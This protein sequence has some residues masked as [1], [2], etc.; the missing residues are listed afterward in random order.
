MGEFLPPDISFRNSNGDSVLLGDVID[1]PLLLAFVY[2][3]CPGICNTTLT[4]LAW[5]VDRVDLIPKDDFEVLCIS[6]DHEETPE[7]ALNSKKNYLTSLQRKFPSDAWHFLVG[8]SV[9][10]NKI[11][12]AAGFH[13]KKYGDEYRHPGGLITISP[14]GKISRYIFGSQ[15]NQFDVK[16]ALIDAE[17]GKTN[18]TVAKMLQF[19]F[20]YDPEGRGYT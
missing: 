14:S 12:D 13:F 11:T 8:D 19:C 6:I 2:Y 1:K 16:M 15:Y 20:S 5:V 4:E 18:P 17:A 3:E 10:V 9:A 7:I